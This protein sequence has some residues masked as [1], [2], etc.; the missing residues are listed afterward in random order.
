MTVSC[1]A[2]GD[3][4]LRAC[5]PWTPAGDAAGACGQGVHKGVDKLV[6]SV[7]NF[8]ARSVCAIPR[9]PR[10]HAVRGVFDIFDT[11]FIHSL[12]RC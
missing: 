4:R 10:R 9:Y 1:A 3:S 2:F 6:D 5:M 12:R 8:S 11:R 7:D